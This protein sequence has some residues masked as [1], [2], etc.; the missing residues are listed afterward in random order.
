MKKLATISHVN[1]NIAAL[2]EAADCLSGTQEFLRPSQVPLSSYAQS[3]VQELQASQ[4]A[5]PIPG[6][7]SLFS[8]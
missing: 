7:R 5:V 2:P 4:L 3:K 8:E 6:L 1:W